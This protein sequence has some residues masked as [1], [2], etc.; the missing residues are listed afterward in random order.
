ML[1]LHFIFSSLVCRPPPCPHPV[2]LPPLPLVRPVKCLPKCVPGWVAD[3]IM[4]LVFCN[5][6]GWVG[7]EAESTPLE[8]YVS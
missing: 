6:A 4:C 5:R 1:F 8:V 7:G 2:H 3:L